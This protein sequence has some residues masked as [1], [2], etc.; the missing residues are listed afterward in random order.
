MFCAFTVLFRL[1]YHVADSVQQIVSAWMELRYIVILAAGQ[2]ESH[3]ELPAVM[4]QALKFIARICPVR[5]LDPS[6]I[7]AG[8]SVYSDQVVFPL[9]PEAADIIDVFSCT[10]HALIE[11]RGLPAFQ[12]DVLLRVELAVKYDDVSRVDQPSY[13]AVSG[14]VICDRGETLVFAAYGFRKLFDLFR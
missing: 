2:I 12:L 11:K 8:E 6:D 9:A 7:L 14:F 13:I 1:L 5:E 10:V 3:V 4:E